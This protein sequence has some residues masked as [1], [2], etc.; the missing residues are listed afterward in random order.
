MHT[1]D[2]QEIKATAPAKI[3][4]KLHKQSFAPTDNDRAFM[5]K[6]A[7]RVKLQFNKRVR[8]GN[9]GQFVADLLEIGLFGD[10]RRRGSMTRDDK[11]VLTF[12]AGGHLR[13]GRSADGLISLR[14]DDKTVR[15]T[16]TEAQVLANGYIATLPPPGGLSHNAPA[17]Q[18]GLLV[19]W[20]GGGAK[21]N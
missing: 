2:G 20:L 4:R 16:V 11:V 1:N 5:R 18:T 3:V 8:C 9:P 15:L 13:L 6:T 19:A 12:A 10:R 7:D 14:L 21:L 17:F